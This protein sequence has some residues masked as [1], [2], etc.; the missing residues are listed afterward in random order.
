[1][2][3]LAGREPD[4]DALGIDALGL[5]DHRGAQHVGV[6]RGGE[7]VIGVALAAL[8][9]RPHVALAAPAIREA[10]ARVLAPQPEKS[11]QE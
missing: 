5:G 2:A 1:M 10:R 7:R 11:T 3:D 8:A 9:D 4:A 6:A